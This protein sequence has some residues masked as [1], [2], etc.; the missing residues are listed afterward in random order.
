[1]SEGGRTY[2]IAEA[3]ALLPELRERLERV[4]AARQRLIRAGKRIT[5]KVAS[6][7][8]GVA[9]TD[10]F[11][12]Q[13]GLRDEIVWLSERDIALRDPESGLIDFP[14][15]REGEEVWLCWRLGEDH[16]GWWHPL[17]SGFISRKPL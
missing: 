12:A 1:V 6:D 14:G 8:G 17:D 3:N 7:G 11:E 5:E 13:R 2:S 10:W 16:V 4:R 15:E 9:G